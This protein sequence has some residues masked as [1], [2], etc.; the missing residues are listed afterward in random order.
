MQLPLRFN[1]NAFRVRSE[2]RIAVA[3]A[4]K[5]RLRRRYLSPP[6]NLNA[7]SIIADEVEL[8]WEASDGLY[9]DGYKIFRDDVEI[10]IVAASTDPLVYLDQLLEAET[11]YN[12]SVYAYNRYG[13]ESEPA[14]TSV[15][16]EALPPL[17]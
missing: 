11:T 9:I 15:I 7:T 16:T 10:A 13:G 6:Q 17:P 4:R 3:G 12:Y 5:R 8:S 2:D 14:V 1:I